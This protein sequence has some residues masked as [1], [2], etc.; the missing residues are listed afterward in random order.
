MKDKPEQPTSVNIHRSKDVN[1]GGTKSRH[2][3]ETHNHFARSITGIVVVMCAVVW[4]LFEN[5]LALLKGIVD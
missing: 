3:N 4:M 2:S 5:V 1:V